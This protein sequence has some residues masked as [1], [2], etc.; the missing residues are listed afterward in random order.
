MSKNTDFADPTQQ[1][2][3]ASLGDR[4]RLARLRRRLPVQWMCDQAGISRM[5]LYRAEAGSPAIAIGTVLRILTVLG[6]QADLDVVARDDRWGR[7]TQ[8]AELR[9]SR[10]ARKAFKGYDIEL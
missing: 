8:D 10:R 9:R 6:L 3:L 2:A 4:I 5:T 1:A 7:L